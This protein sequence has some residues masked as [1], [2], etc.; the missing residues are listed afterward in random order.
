MTRPWFAW[1]LCAAL[2]ACVE[3][4]SLPRFVALDPILDSVFVGD[5]TPLPNVTYFDGDKLQTPP[6]SA[7]TWRSSDPAILAVNNP[8]GTIRGLQ[9][10]NALAIAIVQNVQSSAIVAVSDAV[11]ITL[12]LDT[13]YLLP[14]DAMTIPTIIVHKAP[15][16]PV[17]TYNALTNPSFTVDANG[18]VTATGVPGG[19][20]DYSVTAEEGSVTATATGG[21]YVLDPSSVGAGKAFFTVV[22]PSL[23]SSTVG[24]V[25]ASPEAANYIRSDAG[26]GFHMLA[27]HLASSSP[28]QVAQVTLLAQVTT[29]PATFP[30]DSISPIEATTRAADATC[31]PP[32]AWASRSSA[33]STGTA[34]SGK[35][36]PGQQLSVTQFASDGVGGQV[37]SGRF[38]YRARRS[39]LYTSPLGILRITGVFVAPL[40]TVAICP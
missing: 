35:P 17:V 16:D 33:T 7:V 20:F 11:D 8:P 19:P 27:T 6:A 13:L 28:Q 10:G 37:V 2:A 39:D 4:T 9:R 31:A 18:T 22:G 12:L 23:L 25:D 38:A 40:A 24:H 15:A 14:N 21:V 26:P 32:R 34:Y 5:Q 36:D 3:S 29:A 1:A 30:I